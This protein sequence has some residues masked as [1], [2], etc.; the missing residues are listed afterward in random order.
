MKAHLVKLSF[1]NRSNDDI[2][3]IKNYPKML[4]KEIYKVPPTDSPHQKFEEA[5]KENRGKLDAAAESRSHMEKQTKADNEVETLNGR[6]DTVKKVADER[7][8]KVSL[9]DSAVTV[10]GVLMVVVVVLDW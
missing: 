6:W 8:T 3:M 5:C 9:G 4:L 2:L 7:V 10:V 1:T